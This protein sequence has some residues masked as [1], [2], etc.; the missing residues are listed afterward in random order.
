LNIGIITPT[1]HPNLNGVS[2][3]LKLLVDRL[4]RSGQVNCF[5]VAPRVDG[6]EYPDYVYPVRSIR[7]P[8]KVSSD[9]KIPYFY[10]NRAL[11]FFQESSI[12]IIHSHDPYFSGR[13]G[14]K[15]ARS[16]K[17]PHVHTYHTFVEEYR[18]FNVPGHKMFMRKLS[19]RTC[20]K[21]DAVIAPSKKF[22]DYL[23]K[24]GVTKP[25]TVIH[26]TPNTEGLTYLPRDE[27]LAK[28][29]GITP[30]DFVFITFGRVA[31]EKN[32]GLAIE[33]LA[34]LIKRYGNIKYVIAGI[35]TYFGELEQK[36]I[37]L[38]I[39]N[40]I[41]FTGK[42]DKA[43]IPK[44][45]SVAHC[46]LFTSTTDV[47]PATVLEGMMC[48]LPVISIDDPGVDFILQDGVNGVKRPSEQLTEACEKMYSDRALLKIMSQEAIRTANEFSRRFSID[49]YI[50][51]YRSLL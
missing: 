22:K 41:V 8:K 26:N 43:D 36:A 44:L 45:S 40:N 30:D 18:Y 13:A 6:V 17:I 42:Y 28:E 15:I 37:S 24:I 12:D 51:L 3:S 33:V 21:S 1:Y 11:K 29:Y 32:I 20:N 48:G 23:E 34:P 5:V 19:K 14:I 38:G 46:F 25:V 9:I 39:E 31:M 49:Q 16:L 35:G 47:Q 4:H 2:I 10:R 50:E 27:Q 7:S